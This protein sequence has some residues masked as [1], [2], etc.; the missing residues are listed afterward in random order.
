MDT[1]AKII[2]RARVTPKASGGAG[3]R[4]LAHVAW[5]L[6][7][8]RMWPQAEAIF[9][10]VIAEDPEYARAINNLSVVRGCL[11]EMADAE[12]LARRAIAIEPEN[13][14]YR[15][16][17]ATTLLDLGQF[18]E[19][20]KEYRKVLELDPGD[21]HASASLGI[22]LLR[23]GRFDEA[24]PFYRGRK[25][26]KRYDFL[27]DEFTAWDAEPL[28][29]KALVV[30][31]EQGLGEEFQVARLYT[32]LCGECDDVTLVCDPRI[33]ELMARS[34]PALTVLPHDD[35]EAIRAAVKRADH[36]SYLTNLIAQL[37]PDAKPETEPRDYLRADAGRVAQL[38]KKYKDLYG[39][40]RLIGF[41]WGTSSSFKQS[42]RTI[43]VDQWKALLARDD[44]QFISLQ[45]STSGPVLAEY[46]QNLGVSI[47]VDESIDAKND[48][49]GL[50]AQIAALDQ[51][52]SIDNTTVHLAAALGQPV[53][54]L[55]MKYPHWLW[56]LKGERSGWYPTMRLFRQHEQNDW[57]TALQE[58][59][60]ELEAQ[61]AE[62][63]EPEADE[64]EAD[65]GG[66]ARVG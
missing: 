48:L 62:A 27:K 50:A 6:H 66:C 41:S 21:Q 20:E 16:N 26:P 61:L 33:V 43:P 5:Q 47:G 25:R 3:L 9:R 1:A 54:T 15:S 42:A 64:P 49:D 39:E 4:E 17:L 51:V 45:Y 31:N 65:E 34:F 60:A 55:L 36:V 7:Q 2:P 28:R 63:D 18:S 52:I 29:G 56:G 30:L 40:R 53:W 11:N 24:W 8:N 23:T 19:S 38:R 46:A 14:A 37:A 10:Y 12:K 35:A 59:E 57:T 22:L 13:P 44:C 58:V 32:Q